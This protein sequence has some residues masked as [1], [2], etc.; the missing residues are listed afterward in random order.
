MSKSNPSKP[1]SS[2]LTSHQGGQRPNSVAWYI[3]LPLMFAL[4]IAVGYLLWG[5]K[6][7]F[8]IEQA[9][10]ATQTAVVEAEAQKNFRRYDV[11]TD[12]DP[13]L[14]PANAPI[15]IIEF[16]DYQCP[17]CEQWHQQV[18]TQMRQNYGDKIRFVYRDFPLSFHPQATPA[19][20]AAN[21]ANEQGA[22]WDFHDKLFSG[23]LELGEQA[24]VQYAKD[25]GLDMARFNECVSSRRYASEV[26][27][28][29]D[30][31]ANLGVQST[32][33]FFI[34]GIPLVGAQPYATFKQ[35]I[36]KE[37][38]GGFPK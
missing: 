9:I 14:G 27:S 36:D 28:D 11:P 17:Y 19:A 5:G 23:Q 22:F 20:E 4:G 29:F 32:P 12:D 18:F 6:S 3:L 37:L 16:S 15:T 31:A 7:A 35:V 25:L 1:N 26:Q 33:T 8:K 10:S 24:F 34:N 38:A 30:F 2:D 13:A 21:C